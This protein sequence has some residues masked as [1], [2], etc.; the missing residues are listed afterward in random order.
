LP[1]SEAKSETEA[2]SEAHKFHALHLLIASGITFGTE[3]MAAVLE[4]NILASM[5]ATSEFRIRETM[6]KKG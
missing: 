2:N 4:E 1:H 6:R 3:H 5:G